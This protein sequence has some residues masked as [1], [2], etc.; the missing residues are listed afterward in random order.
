[1]PTLHNP[2]AIVMPEDRRRAVAAI[3]ACHG[4]IVIE[5]DVYGFLLDAPP[6]SIR[7]LAPDLCIYATS[8]SK[9]VAPGLRIGWLAAPAALVPRLAAAIRTSMLMT[10]SVAAELASR[11]VAT[12][13][14]ARAAK[15][16]RDEARARQR[17]A[18]EKLAGFDYRSHPS[19]F[20]GWLGVPPP[21]RRDD[22]CGA[23]QARGVAVTP[24]TAFAGAGVS[25]TEAETRVRLCFC[26]IADRQRLTAALD[27]IAELARSGAPSPLPVV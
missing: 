8:L 20:H 4:M 19:A 2:T 25:P 13:A 11:I 12:G 18:A 21:W 22:F 26:A 3:A 16:Q 17:I 9:A 27:I 24:G 10:S 14:A 5:D 6:P 1:M 15:A 23:L 7:T